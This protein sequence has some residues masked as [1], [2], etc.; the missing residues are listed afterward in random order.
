[1]RNVLWKTIAIFNILLAFLFLLIIV[2]KPSDSFLGTFFTILELITWLMVE[3]P[4]LIISILSF[5]LTN[6]I[7]RFVLI[8]GA[9]IHVSALAWIFFHGGLKMVISYSELRVLREHSKSEVYL[10]SVIKGD[11]QAPYIQVEQPEYRFLHLKN[12]TAPKKGVISFNVTDN[13][14]EVKVELVINEVLKKTFYSPPYTYEYS[15][16]ESTQSD[17]DIKIIAEDKTGNKTLE[18]FSVSTK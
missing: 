11:N 17:L 7:T 4:I 14:G 10:L 12:L 6:K 2:K 18:E 13:K 3:V 8:I 15:L 9:I 16:A 1:M 5:N